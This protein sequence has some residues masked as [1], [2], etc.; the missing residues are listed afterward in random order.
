MKIIL[1]SQSKGRAKILKAMG[2]AFE[3]I[4]PDIDEKAIR[5]PNPA[6]LTLAIARA[7][8]DALL[9]K[10][11]EPA[12]LIT[13]DQVVVCDGAIR[14]KPRDRNEAIAFLESYRKYPAQTVTSVVLTNTANGNRAEGTDI[15]T[16]WF[17][18][19]PD[20][21]IASYVA[22][23]DP[24]SHAGG[25][26]H[27]H[28]ILAPFVRHIHGEEESIMGLPRKLTEILMSEVCGQEFF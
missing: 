1:G 12:A 19:M 10:I 27:E 3:V 17:S 16:I 24:F 9:P 14:E 28:D 5:F 26:A 20:D 6:E 15:A 7:K 23:G 4:P 22:S 25:F 2:F 11:S 13:S 18:V 8:A 21:V